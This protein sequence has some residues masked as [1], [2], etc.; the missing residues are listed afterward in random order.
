MNVTKKKHPKSIVE[1]EIVVPYGSIGVDLDRAAAEVSKEVDIAGFRPGRAPRAMVEKAV[2]ITKLLEAAVRHTIARTLPEAASKEQVTESIG[3]P[4]VVIKKL[5][6]DNDIVYTA[7]ITVLPEVALKD[8]EQ[9]RVARKPLDI[10]VEKGDK[11]LQ[12]L[13]KMRAKEAAVTRPA[14]QGDK[15][16]MDMQIKIAGVPVEGGAQYGMMLWLG[17]DVMIPGFVEKIEGASIGQKL[18]FELSFPEKYHARHLAGKT[19]EFE[20]TIKNIFEVSLPD[21]NDEFAA[22]VGNFKSLQE[23]R[24][25]LEKNIRE[26]AEAEEEFRLEKAL[27]HELEQRATIGEIPDILLESELERMHEELKGSLVQRGVSYDDWLGQLK[28]TEDEVKR[29]LRPQ[30]ASRVKTM[31]AIRQLARDRDITVLDED[32]D[33]EINSLLVH[34]PGQKD[35]E[36]RVRQESYRDVLKGKIL[37]RKV[38]EWMK[39]KCIEPVEKK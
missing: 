33:E 17:E 25:Q 19:G 16:L 28:K 15:V 14:K 21:L 2:G 34:Y 12:D 8:V 27:L 38:I 3:R 24:E 32:I 26:E 13:K 35:I 10:P 22:T 20:V 31:L 1:L 39:E 30:A 5:L 29:D 11:V 6:P 36:E 37:N 7:R 18:V 4:E 23:L 9:I